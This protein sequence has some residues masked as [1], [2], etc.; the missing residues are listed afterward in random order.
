MTGNIESDNDD[1]WLEDEIQQQL[2]QLDDN[3]LLSDDEQYTCKTNL[4]EKYLSSVD[5]KVLNSLC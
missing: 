3:C 1:P 4:S 2:D 5:T